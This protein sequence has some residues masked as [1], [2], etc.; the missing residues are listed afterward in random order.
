M[1]ELR[2]MPDENSMR[3][4]RYSMWIVVIVIVAALAF[5]KKFGEPSAS[6]LSAILTGILIASF[7]LGFAIEYSHSHCQRCPDCT[8]VMREVDEDVHPKAEDYHILY[9]ERCDIIWDTT[10][11]KSN[12]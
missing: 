2:K 10:I 4:L 1:S 6:P 7:V 5:L 9:C 11:P 8:K 12:D 3:I